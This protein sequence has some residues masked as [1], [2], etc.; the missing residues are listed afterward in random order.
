[1]SWSCGL[2]AARWSPLR[3]RSLAE[4][5][6]SA[7]VAAAVAK[8]Y[9]RAERRQ[10]RMLTRALDDLLP[11]EH[12][13]RLV[14]DF[15]ARQDLSAYYADMQTVEGGLVGRRRSGDSPCAVAHGDDRRHW[16]RATVGPTL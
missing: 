16:Q 8:R 7:V 1:M 12:P 13:A 4:R 6:A 15:V 5:A 14:W 2:R 3:R 11:P 10:V 9:Q